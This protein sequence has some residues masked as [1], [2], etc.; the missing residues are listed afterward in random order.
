MSKSNTELRHNCF[1]RVKEELESGKR[2]D[3]ISRKT[4]TIGLSYGGCFVVWSIFSGGK[5]IAQ[6]R[7]PK[8]SE[9]RA[10][11]EAY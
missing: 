1:E 9:T 6:E 11:M 10:T 5:W 2:P 3:M 8:T 7:K 4:P